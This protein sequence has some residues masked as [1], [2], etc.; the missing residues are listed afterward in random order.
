MLAGISNEFN[1]YHD[2][3]WLNMKMHKKGLSKWIEDMR[4]QN[5]PADELA[6]FAL[7]RLYKRHSVIY[8][9][10]CTWSTIGTL[11]PLSEKDV[12]LI[13]DVKFVQMGPWNFISL[14]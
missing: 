3:S 10:N 11:K 2:V 14:I 13:C 1:Y 7:S 5:T 6:I 9:K 4:D 8:T 12:Y